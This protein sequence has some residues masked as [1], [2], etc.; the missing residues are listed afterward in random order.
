MQEAKFG[1]KQ[2]ITIQKRGKLN[3]VFCMDEEHPV[4]KGHHI[5][6][7]KMKTQGVDI[8]FQ[9]GPRNEEG[10]IEGVLD[11]DLLE[12]VLDRLKSFQSGPYATRENA[13][14]ITKIEE[15]LL[16]MNKRVEDRIEAGTLGTHKV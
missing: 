13:I 15:A 7:I 16:W 8:H 10:S 11:V 3:T 2:L 1:G 5:Y 4:N 12:I 9:N 6:S 14:A